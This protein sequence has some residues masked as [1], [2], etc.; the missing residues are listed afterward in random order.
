MPKKSSWTLHDMDEVIRMREQE[1]M[2][3]RDI[4]VAMGR[5]LPA[6]QAK[7]DYLTRPLKAAPV[8]KVVPQD[9]EDDRRHRQTTAPRSLTASFFGDPLPGYSALDQLKLTHQDVAEI[10]AQW[11]ALPGQRQS[12]AKA[13]GVCPDTI[14][15]VING[16]Y[17][18][19]F[20]V[21]PKA[22]AAE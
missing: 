9:C 13:Y 12:L 7:Y 18:D 14:S 21:M 20:V 15:K 8:F 2:T 6:C 17:W 16:R 3:W 10:E 19:H 5:S 11:R 22:E 1:K 4:S